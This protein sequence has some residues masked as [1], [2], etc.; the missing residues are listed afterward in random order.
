MTALGNTATP[1]ISQIAPMPR[2]TSRRQFLGQAAL[3][4]VGAGVATSLAG[5]IPAL[6][7]R[8]FDALE[9]LSDDDREALLEL[10][11]QGEGAARPAHGTE[12]QERGAGGELLILVA[13]PPNQL[14]IHDRNTYGNG[15]AASLV[16]EPLMHYLSDGT[17]VPNLV[18]DVPSIA[19]GLVSED[20]TSVTYRLLPEVTWSDGEPFTAEDVRFTWKWHLNPENQSWTNTRAST[21]EDVEVE[22]DLTVTVRFAAPTPDWF[23]VHTWSQ[24]GVIYPHHLLIDGDIGARDAFTTNPIGTGPFTVESFTPGKYVEYTANERYREPNKPYFSSVV[25]EHYEN[26]QQSTRDFFENGTHDFCWRLAGEGEDIRAMAEESDVADLLVGPGSDSIH[27]LNINFSD[28]N[29]RVDGQRSEMNTPHPFLTERAVREAISL[30]IDR[31]ALA[32]VLSVGPELD[33]PPA[34]IMDPYPAIATSVPAPTY[35]PERAKEVLEAAGWVEQG[36][37][38]REK[39]GVRL[40]LDYRNLDLNR[41]GDAHRMVMDNLR[42]VGFGVTETL[43]SYQFFWDASP[44]NDLYEGNFYHDLQMLMPSAGSPIP[45]NLLNC[46]Y[47]GPNGENIAQQ[48]NQWHGSNIARYNNPDYDALYEQAISATDHDTVIDLCNQ[49][50]DMLSQDHVVIPL[51]SQRSLNGCINTL[52]KANLE[53]GPFTFPTWNIANWNRVR[54]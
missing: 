25:L 42:A 47:A 16:Q 48:S 29:T 40:E 33:P 1:G 18:R 20:L 8:D 4:G 19:N 43:M 52:N 54:E 51:T 28:P 32:Y 49:M 45:L 22:D 23:H 44:G 10:L 38:V 35:D 12:G 31:D 7:R 21:I 2:T 46:W 37:G 11:Q 39:N 9:E 27:S 13:S 41:W 6:A 53:L 15:L 50:S 3:G 26:H 30:A 5:G 14:F 24:F 36:D 17:I 34:S